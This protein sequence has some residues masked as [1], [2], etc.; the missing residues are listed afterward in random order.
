MKILYKLK[1]FVVIFKINKKPKTYNDNS[2]KNLCGTR[3]FVDLK[4]NL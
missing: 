2:I 3:K 4:L 1:K